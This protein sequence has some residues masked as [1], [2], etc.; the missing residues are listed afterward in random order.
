MRLRFPR[1]I[2]AE[3]C[4]R[5][6]DDRQFH[7]AVAAALP[8]WL[9]GYFWMMPD[10][11]WR[12][13]LRVPR[14]LLLLGLLYPVAEEALF[15]GMLQGW[16]LERGLARRRLGITG[17]NWLTSGLFTGLHFIAHPPLAAASVLLPSLIFG[18]FRDRHGSLCAPIVLHVYY[19]LGYFWIF[20][21]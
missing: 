20:A 9:V 2:V 21:S 5:L 8:V 13:P 11:D 3:N 19:N 17:A 18:H 6:L 15:R 1:L 12:W 14:E 16:L 7:W 10:P 4:A